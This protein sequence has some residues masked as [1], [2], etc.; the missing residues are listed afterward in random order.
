MIELVKHEKENPYKLAPHLSDMHI[1]PGHFQKMKVAPAAE[2]MSHKTACA[3]EKLVDDGLLSVKA[4][5]TAWFFKQV[6]KWFDL[7]CSRNIGTAFSQGKP[8][9]HEKAVDFMQFFINLFR[10]IKIADGAWKPV[11]TGVLLSTTSILSLQEDLLKEG[12]KFV[13]TSR[14]TQDSL[15]NLFSMIRARNPIPT[16]Y[17]CKMAL[18]VISVSQYLKPAKKGSYDIDDGAFFLADYQSQFPDSVTKVIEGVLED[19]ADDTLP[20]M[21]STEESAFV[22]MSGYLASSVLKN[23]R[24]CRMCKDSILDPQNDSKSIEFIR[25]K[26]YKDGCLA[27]PSHNLVSLMQ[28]CEGIFVKHAPTL[29]KQANNVKR[30]QDIMM[31]ST[32]GAHFPECHS[33][34]AHI[35]QRFIVFRIR[36]YLKDLSKTQRERQKAAL[37][38]RKFAS[39]STARKAAREGSSCSVLQT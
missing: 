1:S 34:K 29:H 25:S 35:I 13:L 38:V 36:I 30:L 2:L 31:S 26:S 3:I 10:N 16:P 18:R 17:Q 32:S 9:Q 22:Y 8:E 39:V 23:N 6:S 33:I 14:F 20:E 4:R 7:M 27:S 19:N 37:E 24:T 15:E 21:S 12:Y 28:M 5:T 11:Q